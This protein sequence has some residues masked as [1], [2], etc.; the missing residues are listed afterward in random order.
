MAA[1]LDHLALFRDDFVTSDTGA[2]AQ[3]D[4]PARGQPLI[5]GRRVNREVVLFDQD[6]S[7]EGDG[8]LARLAD[9][10][11]EVRGRHRLDRPFR[12]GGDGDREGTK[13]AEDPRGRPVEIVADAELEL[14]DVDG[15]VDF[16]DANQVGEGP[17]GFGTDAPAAHRRR[18][19]ASVDRPSR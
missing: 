17:D 10:R 1:Q 16:G 11:G 14:V 2:V 18:S 13:H 8:P 6:L 9:V 12:P 4:R 19:S 15:R 3:A 5:A 7:L